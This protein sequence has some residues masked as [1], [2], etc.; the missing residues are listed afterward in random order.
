M[1]VRL[2]Y[3]LLAN[4]QA[5]TSN[6]KWST[7]GIRGTQPK[8]IQWWTKSNCMGP[9]TTKTKTVVSFEPHGAQRHCKLLPLMEY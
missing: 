7:L 5:K 1:H 4:C 2:G 9:V 8:A 3:S 6:V